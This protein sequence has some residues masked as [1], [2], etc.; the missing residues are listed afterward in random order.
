MTHGAKV[1]GVHVVT[2]K[3]EPCNPSYNY[4]HSYSFLFPRKKLLVIIVLPC[5]P[6]TIQ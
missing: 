5:V 2:A 1:V 6:W 3:N 4:M